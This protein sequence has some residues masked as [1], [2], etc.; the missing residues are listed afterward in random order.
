MQAMT[1]LLRQ[2]ISRRRM[3]AMGAAGA[4]LL[5]L[6][7]SAC[8]PSIIRRLRQIESRRFPRHA[9]WIWQFSYDGALE[10]V[11]STLA[12]YGLAAIVKTHD[13]VEWMAKYDHAP[14]AI[15]GPYEVRHAAEVFE[16]AGVPFHAWAV[17]RGVDP[18]REAQMAADVLDA[19][20]RSVTLDL[21]EGPGFWEG[22]REGAVR[23]GAELRA[24]HEFARVDISIDARPWK[25]FGIPLAEFVE[26][27]DGIRPQLYWDLF[28]DQD[29]VNAYGVFDEYAS[30]GMTPEFLVDATARF[31]APYDRWILPV[32]PASPPADSDQ[33]ARFIRRARERQMPEVSAWRYGVST[34]DV[35][36]ALAADPPP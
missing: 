20:A 9:V 13:G 17:V 36:H 24:R 7:N 4:G 8:H 12:A 14:G 19:G 34:A 21:E 32:G 25:W 35:L 2:R 30:D 11:A 23:F 27:S 31:L 22:T 33:W 28:D 5:A 6:G 29:H 26:F 3:L 10:D 16:A 1:S 15:A 18:V